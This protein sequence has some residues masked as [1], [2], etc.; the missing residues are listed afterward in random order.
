MIDIIEDIVTE[1]NQVDGLNKKVYRKWPSK[2]AKGPS[3]LV[4]RI[5]AVPTF[6]DADGSE[7][8]VQLTYS[9]EVN[10]KDADEADRL[11]SDIIDRMAGYNL[12]R[13][14]DVELYDDISRNW[15]RII[16]VHGT[17]D[18]RGN[19]FTS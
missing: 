17:V 19:T 4:Q 9:I 6:T 12:H 13:S 1:L 16:T 2:A 10:A 3:C 7:V 5:S 18:R 15:R 8:T 14:G 11:A